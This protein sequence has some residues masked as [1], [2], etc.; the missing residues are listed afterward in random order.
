M[1][2]DFPQ[3]LAERIGF[4]ALVFSR[5]GYG[6]S[7][8]A[9]LPRRTSYMHEEAA[10]LP[11]LCG[12]LGISRP[13]LVGHSDGASIALIYAGSNSVPRPSALLLEA[14]HVFV[15]PISIASIAKARETFQTTDFPA[16]LQRYHELPVSHVFRGW[17]DIW[18]HP[19]FAQWNIEYVL[20]RVT[21]PTLVVQGE[22]DEYGTWAQVAAIER[23]LAGQVTT[24]RVPACGHSPHVD[25]RERTL[26]AM[27]S[28]AKAHFPTGGPTLAR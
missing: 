13:V 4:G 18:L 24:V 19:D 16:R 22:K 17:N 2:R 27:A 10:E 5:R 12:A 3:A 14:P 8:E 1:W 26:D 25:Q 28:F 9:H 15:E 20:S 6:A 11:A 7:S 21:A 23:A